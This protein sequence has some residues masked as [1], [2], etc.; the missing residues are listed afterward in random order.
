VGVDDCG[1][2]QSF[3]AQDGQD[4][5]WPLGGAR[6]EGSLVL[7]YGRIQTPSSDG[8]GY[9]QVGWRALVVDDPDDRA[10]LASPDDESAYGYYVGGGRWSPRVE[11]AWPV[12]AG[13]GAIDVAW[14]SAQGRWLAA[15]VPP[16][17]DTITPRSGLSPA[18]P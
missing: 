15:Y 6:I 8:H 17:G 18:G 4:W 16:L 11:D 7:F 9:Q 2:P 3:V 5:F 10:P 13:G 12:T 14:L 1:S